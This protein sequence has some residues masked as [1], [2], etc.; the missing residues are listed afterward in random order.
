MRKDMLTKMYEIYSEE[1]EDR[2][3]ELFSKILD[4]VEKI[5]GDNKIVDEIGDQLSD[6]MN[7][8][9]MDSANMVLDF[10]SGKE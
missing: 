2:S 7:T 10:I 9:F 3:S 4:K 5:S 8:V 1:C 6:F